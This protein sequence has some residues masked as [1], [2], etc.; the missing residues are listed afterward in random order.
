MQS[1]SPG[2]ADRRRPGSWASACSDAPWANLSGAMP[3][4]WWPTHIA[5]SPWLEHTP[6]AA[7]LIEVA[8]PSRLVEL[9]APDGVSFMAFCQA[10]RRLPSP[11]RCHA[12]DPR[13]DD[14]KAGLQAEEGSG[15]LQRLARRH[16]AVADLLRMDAEEALIRFADGSVDMTHLPH[17][18]RLCRRASSR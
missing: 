2:K 13:E 7:W 4:A 14:D 6:F 12:V 15:S 17:A 3:A 11:P 8:Q 18:G 1:D 5:A 9:E 10:A 16:A